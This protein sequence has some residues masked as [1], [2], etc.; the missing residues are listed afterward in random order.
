MHTDATDHPWPLSLD[1]PSAAADRAR[2]ALTDAVRSSAPALIVADRGLDTPSIARAIHERG[3][4][5]TPLIVID[6]A[7]SDVEQVERDLFGAARADSRAD[8]AA[9]GTSSAL[10]RVRG[11]TLHLE[12]VVDL[13]AGTQRRL[14]RILRDREVSVG[15]RRLPVRGRI[16]GDAPASVAV[17]VGEGHFRSDLFRRLSHGLSRAPW[18]GPDRT[19]IRIRYRPAR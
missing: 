11:G 9:V 19:R 6:C 13:P 5:G 18:P 14:A 12:H 4:P 2:A 17:E 15:G 16:I 8:L 7:A 1:G 3:R 10:L